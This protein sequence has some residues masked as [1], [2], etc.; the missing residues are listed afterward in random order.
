M[1]ISGY[2]HQQKWPQYDEAKTVEDEIE[3]VIQINGRNKTKIFISSDMSREDM[4]QLVYKNQEILNVLEG[5]QPKK[6]IAVPK[7]LINIVV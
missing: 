4:E 5:K 2:I 7:R 3:I 6:V 1:R